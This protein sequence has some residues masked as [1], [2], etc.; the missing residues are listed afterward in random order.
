MNTL[1]KT[2]PGL[3]LFGFSFGLDIDSHLVRDYLLRTQRVTRIC[4]YVERHVSISNMP[5]STNLARL[6]RICEAV[7][8]CSYKTGSFQ[9]RKLSVNRASHWIL[10]SMHTLCPREF[11]VLYRRHWYSFRSSYHNSSL[12]CKVHPK[13]YIQSNKLALNRTKIVISRS[14]V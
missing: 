7:S 11:R 2:S 6:R 4:H 14:W 13:Q 9:E 10:F 3:F 12:R 5:S 1:R 8:A